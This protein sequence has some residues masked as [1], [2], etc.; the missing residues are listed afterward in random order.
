MFSRETQDVLDA[1]LRVESGYNFFVTMPPAVYRELV[2]KAR[3]W[4][5]ANSSVSR[6]DYRPEP[7]GAGA[8]IRFVPTP[9][10]SLSVEPGEN[11]GTGGNQ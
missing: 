8:F 10:G 5:V 9:D 11:P 1:N 3:A 2:M 4:E 7:P 6:G